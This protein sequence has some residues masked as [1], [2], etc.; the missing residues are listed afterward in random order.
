MLDASDSS[1]LPS[2][3]LTAFFD[4]KSTPSEQIPRLPMIPGNPELLLDP[5]GITLNPKP[6]TPNPKPQT[7][8]PKP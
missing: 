2:L 5:V 8:N 7:L 3:C 1:T 4:T 6:Q